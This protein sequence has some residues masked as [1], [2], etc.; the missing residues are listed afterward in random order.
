MKRP[1]LKPSKSFNI[2]FKEGLPGQPFFIFTYMELR[3]PP[4]KL[5]QGE[6]RHFFISHLHRIYC[7]KSQL[8]EKLPEIGKRSHYVD[9]QQAINET[10]EIVQHQI[11]RM[12][13]IYR[14]IDAFYQPESC[15]GLVGMLDEAFQSIG[16]PQDS[17]A[18]RDLSILFYMQNIESIEMASFK[19]MIYVAGKLEQP[20]IAQLLL[21]CYDEAREDKALLKEITANY[22]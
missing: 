13:E 18:L 4:K 1:R 5:S 12:K 2:I 20:D 11:A 21:E 16:D 8:I 22:L 3:T 14:K 9:L 7:A 19:T 6:L 15:I 10:V 17:A